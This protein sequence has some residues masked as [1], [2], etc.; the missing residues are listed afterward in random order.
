M[1]RQ[2][3]WTWTEGGCPAEL[4]AGLRT[5]AA[6][7]PARFAAAGGRALTFRRVARLAAGGL[8]V[9]WDAGG[10]R[11]LYGRPIDAFR[12]VGR[13]L[14][15][16]GARGAFAVSA[17]FEML[18]VMFGVSR[19][20][21]L[22]PATVRALLVRM[23]LMGLNTLMLYAEDTYEVPGEPFFGYCRGRYAQ[24]DLKALDR[25]AARLGIE[26]F[27]CIQTLGHLQQILKW[28]AYRHL[29]D[30]PAVLLADEPATYALLEKMIRAAS[31][32]FRS[33]R[34]HIGMDEAHGIGTGRY[35][36]KHGYR[37]PI[38]ILNEHLVRVRGLCAKLGLRPMIWSDMFFRLGSKTHDYYDPEAR[39]TPAMKKRLPKDVQLVYWDYYH[40]D[41][42]FYRTFIRLHR[43]LGTEPVMAGGVWTWDRFWMH[44]PFTVATTNPCL[45]ACKALGVREAFVTLWGD[46]GQE[47]DPFSA[48]PGL[49][50][51]AEHGYADE[52]DERVLRANFRGATG[53]DYDA[54]IKPA[55]LDQVQPLDARATTPAN[56]S[57]A[58]LWDDPFLGLVQPQLGAWD[59][60]AYY[61]P[62]AA[63]L[64][65]LARRPGHARLAMPAAL[66]DALARKC[67]LQADVRAAY[68]ARD[69]AR[70][71]RLVRYDL[72]QTTEAIVVLWRLHRSLWLDT[73]EPFGWEVLEGRYGALLARLEHLGDRLADFAGGELQSIPEFD[74]RRVP[75]N[76]ARRGELPNYRYQALATASCIR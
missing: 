7:Y 63:T 73:Y 42:A 3:V 19:N 43:E 54:W 17:R 44:M 56:R 60:R 69:R 1:A 27:P 30:V 48:L 5:I 24:K 12:A 36:Q 49:Q 61:R 35:L 67:G 18:G 57:K 62:L 72:V 21:V 9:A 66:A 41:E 4:R 59:A 37:D 16:T 13:L 14:G 15:A 10:A 33:K 64:S 29:A 47:C 39:F 70:F 25:F 45:R 58:L 23:A 40:Q 34:I 76:P 51:F 71:R 20:G 11:I 50:Y 52:I 75:L 55:E 28:P 8:D 46:D 22:R 68:R 2:G 6:I 74:A 32:P 31:A 53:L 38:K 26:M 65:R